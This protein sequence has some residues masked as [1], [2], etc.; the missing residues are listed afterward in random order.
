M[1]PT[2]SLWGKNIKKYFFDIFSQQKKKINK[3]K[4]Q[5]QLDRLLVNSL[6]HSKWL[7]WQQIK[8]LSKVL[9]QKEK[10]KIKLLIS[11]IIVCLFILTG[12]IYLTMTVVVPRSGGEYVEG[13]IG[14]PRF[15]NPILAHND[16]DLD[17][18]YL[19]FSGLM[20]WDKN[21]QLVPDLAESFEISDN[22][23]VYTFYL[24]NGI[25]W[26]DGQPFRPDDIIFTVAS[27]QD[28]N[29]KSPLALSFRGVVAEKVDE[30]TVRFILKEPFAPFLG[31]LTFGIIPE[32]LWYNI[33]PANSDLTELNR[34]PVGT[35]PW[36]FLSSTKDK[37][38]VIR[39]YTLVP[40]Q[41]YHD[42]KPYLK[43]ITFRFYGDFATAAETLK[44]KQI[45]AIAYL[46]K[47]L[48][49]GIEKYKNLNY[50]QLD[51]P[52][53]TAIFF[54]QRNN[55]L[56]KASH[57]RQALSLAVDKRKIIQEALGLEARAIEVPTL[58]GIET[59]AEIKHYNYDPAAAIE[60]LEKNGWLLTTTT[61]IDGTTESVR[62]KGNNY[63]TINLKTVNQAENIKIAEMIKNF[64]QIIGF[65]T[66]LE[67]VDR[68][69]IL[70]ETIR[71]R[72]YEALLFAQN[73]GSD[74]DPFPFWHSSQNEHP[75]LNLAIFTNRQA[76]TLLENAR[77]SNDWEERQKN[78]SEFQKIIAEELPAIFLYNPT[79]NYPQDKKIKGFDLS[80]IAVP[81]DRFANLAEWYIKT[82]RIFK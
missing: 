5:H 11:I 42:Q 53:Y 61:T 38:G 65:Q 43:K 24:K 6:S 16:V 28:P 52:Q 35:G 33:P 21:R 48:R 59:S 13:L 50:H 77:K 18:S 40:N 70:Q 81:A 27:I 67:I 7:N 68:T 32:H 36:K 4:Q 22:Q 78:Y 62:K 41:D 73:L 39:S 71:N 54:N 19:I 2:F 17:L 23:L 55:D 57:I 9:D 58:P 1:T 8:C 45:Q 49:P 47:E 60:I 3:I 37:A 80:N 15:I 51:Q 44:N 46:P 74:P 30:R 10:N 26:H 76:D 34:Q 72:D 75:G 69:K 64:W 66:N 79:Y 20:K 29:F 31:L 82:K 25:K 14:S 63:L 12:Q 56:I